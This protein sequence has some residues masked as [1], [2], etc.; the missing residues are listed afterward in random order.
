MKIEI[1]EFR[2]IPIF[3]KT[4]GFHKAKEATF[5]VNGDK[6]TLQISKE[7]YDAGRAPD[8]IKK[9]A[10]KIIAVHNITIK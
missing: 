9:E 3:S 1:I 4:D 8:L 6:H 5:T 2:E 7:D 10:E